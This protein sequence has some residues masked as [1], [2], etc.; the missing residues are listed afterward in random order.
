MSKIRN[1]YVGEK[2]YPLAGF[3]DFLNG[4][5]GNSET[6]IEDDEIDNE[7]NKIIA[8]QDSSFISQQ[9]KAVATTDNKAGGKKSKSDRINIKAA[10]KGETVKSISDRERD[11]E[12]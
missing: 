8:E 5:F 9:E 11:E 2:I 7:V 3:K 4:L 12:R 10:K 1:N 6:Y